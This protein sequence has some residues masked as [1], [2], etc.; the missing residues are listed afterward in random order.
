MNINREVDEDDLPAIPPPLPPFRSVSMMAPPAMPMKQSFSRAQ[1][2]ATYSPS[3]DK[4]LKLQKS[5]F[6][7][8]TP[9]SSASTWTWKVTQVAPVPLY[10][11]LERT[12]I[13]SNDSVDIITERI[14]SFMKAHSVQCSYQEDMARVNCSTDCCVHFAVQLWRKNSSIIIEVQRRQ[15]CAIAMQA[16]RQQL[17]HCILHGE[18]SSLKETSAANASSSRACSF[19]KQMPLPASEERLGDCL[20]LCQRFLESD[21]LDQNR[22]GLESLCTLTDPSKVLPKDAQDTSTLMLQDATM[23]KLLLKFF[24]ADTQAM[25][26]EEH[27]HGTLHLLALKA[28]AGA[29]ETSNTTTKDAAID[30]DSVFW[31]TVLQAY[32]KNIQRANQRPIEASLSIRS[33]RLLQALEPSTMA[34]MQ[35]PLD[36]FLHVAHEYGRQHSQSL[37]KETELLMMNHVY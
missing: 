8:I 2:K 3:Q 26:H 23:Q 27:F 13:S 25:G 18:D 37:Q 36:Q 19:L 9:T 16:L 22:L 34:T 32:Y 33:L 1:S 20:E 4:Q 11:P 5:H 17:T 14:S 29:V 31:Q 21:L 12:A 35:Q 10:H 30:I 7:P 28:L 6:T 24:K 15:G